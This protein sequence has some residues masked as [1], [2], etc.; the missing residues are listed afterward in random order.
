LSL[1]EGGRKRKRRKKSREGNRLEDASTIY[2]GE[3]IP[4]ARGGEG[5]KRGGSLIWRMGTR[6]GHQKRIPIWGG[7]LW[8]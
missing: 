3:A 2:W 5:E 7:E 8:R 1:L 6:C 4:L